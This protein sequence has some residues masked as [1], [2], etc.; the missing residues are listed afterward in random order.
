MNGWRFPNVFA[1]ILIVLIMAALACKAVLPATP[2]GDA[3]AQASPTVE[4]LQ[5][6]EDQELSEPT[7]VT[8][9]KVIYQDSFDDQTSGWQRS[10]DATGSVDYA[11]GSYRIFVNQ[12]DYLLWSTAGV[13]LSDVQVEV[14]AAKVSGPDDNQF[15]VIC[16]YQDEDNFYFLV[17]SSDGYYAIGKIKDGLITVLGAEGMHYN[18]HIH[19]GETTNQI[20]ARCSGSRLELFA[21]DTRLGN[22]EDLDFSTGDVGLL[23]GTFDVQGADIL[24]DDFVVTQP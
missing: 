17:I 3:P 5:L 10:Q 19:Q 18:E 8:A 9:E 11:G 2:V 13:D 1:L 22:V 21:N 15:G 24:F 14:R 4:G 16:R 6:E 7:P 23:V 20:R 12:P